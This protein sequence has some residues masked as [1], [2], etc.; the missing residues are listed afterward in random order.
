MI[1]DGNPSS[2]LFS[3]NLGKKS[4]KIKFHSYR[5]VL[6]SLQLQNVEV[7]LYLVV[8]SAWRKIFGGG[9]CVAQDA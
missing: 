6:S 2:T 1:I 8:G 7:G 9:K 5:I 3:L 4:R